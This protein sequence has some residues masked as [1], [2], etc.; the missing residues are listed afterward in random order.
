MGE[1]ASRAGMFSGAGWLRSETA[2]C[3][4]A[5][6]WR[7][8]RSCRVVGWG[9]AV[10]FYLGGM[11]LPCSHDLLRRRQTPLGWFTHRSIAA[12]DLFAERGPGWKE[13]AL[14]EKKCWMDRPTY[15]SPVPAPPAAVA[16]SLWPHVADGRYTFSNVQR[17]SKQ[18]M[19]RVCNDSI[20]P[21]VQID[22]PS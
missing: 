11:R 4:G 15:L 8:C 22:S 20:R 14:D 7:T 1:L 12:V 9:A 2:T 10:L 21:R 5:G 3:R 16:A 13:L 6:E 19:N 18:W 17:F